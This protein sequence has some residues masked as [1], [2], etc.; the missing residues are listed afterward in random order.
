MKKFLCSLLILS[1]WA[2]YGM[3]Q[4]GPGEGGYGGVSLRFQGRL[5][6]QGTCYQP[7]ENI[8]RCQVPEGSPGVLELEAKRSPAGP[9]NIRLVSPPAGWPPFHVASDLRG[10]VQAQYRFTIPPGTAGS[11]FELLFEA[12]TAGVPRPV[13]LQV[14][15]EVISVQPP[16]GPEYPQP[17]YITDTQGRFSVPVEE[18][19]DTVVSGTLTRCGIQPLPGVPVSVELIPKEGRQW[20]RNL[21]DIGA[22]RVSSPGYGEAVVSEFRLLSSMD[23]TGRVQRTIDVGV[24]CLR[25]TGTT[26]GPVITWP[27]VPRPTPMR[28]TTDEKG[29]FTV[30]LPGQPGTTVTGRLT[31]CTVRPLPKQ[32][33]ELTPIYEGGALRGFTLDVPGYEPVTVTEFSRFSLFGLTGYLLGDVCLFLKGGEEIGGNGDEEKKEKAISCPIMQ[34]RILTQ[35]TMLFD[36]IG[37]LKKAP[38]LEKREELFAKL[39]GTS[40][41]DIVGLQEVFREEEGQKRILS[42]WLKKIGINLHAAMKL[43]DYALKDSTINGVELKDFRPN[44]RKVVFRIVH[45]YCIAGPDSAEAG[46]K[47]K[48]RQDAGLM[49]LSKYPIVMASAFMFSASEDYDSWT[50][51][52]ALYARINLAPKSKREDCYIHVFVTHLQAD[53]EC[54]GQYTRI[55]DSQLREL[56][57]FIEKCTGNDGH[58]IVLLG[59][60]NI[61]ADKPAN[62]GKDFTC[63]GWKAAG[64][65]VKTYYA[66]ASKVPDGATVWLEREAVL[67]ERGSVRFKFE[68]SSEAGKDFLRFYVD[69]K[70]VGK[71]SGKTK[72]TTMFPLTPGKHT[73]RWAYSKDGSGC[74]GKDS[75]WLYWVK[76]YDNGKEI[77]DEE[78]GEI[79]PPWKTGSDTNKPT[80]SR[81]YRKLTN[82]FKAL[83]LTDVWKQLRPNDPGFTYIGDWKTGKD[84]PWGEFGNVLA[85]IRGDKSGPERLDYIFYYPGRSVYKLKPLNIELVPSEPG[86]KFQLDKNTFTYT[87]SDHLGV[88]MTCELKPLK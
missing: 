88:A 19:P 72:R 32:E 54:A 30:S 43:G 5:L 56:K 37:G 84:T 73:L 50:S 49:L 18:L 44:T 60:F 14:I 7:A 13:Q 42:H 8:L 1:F 81:E 79:E 46:I 22:V 33:F 63:P 12:W 24:V 26:T 55:R 3:A 83:Q 28:G 40:N 45:P 85:K 21:G 20:I 52:G 57:A 48:V 6:T 62:W 82:L 86:K 25:P 35:N 53:Y 27:I 31:E 67:K 69:G 9:V 74:A 75:A 87:L 23:I 47:E 78:F 15:L 10:T 34:L 76:V 38:Y 16:T 61:V 77:V 65:W 71:W 68:V 51:K 80:K 2:L 70:E 29:E 36:A 64:S 58:P 39:I 59:D 17:G 41:Y 4:Y 11:Q 66:E